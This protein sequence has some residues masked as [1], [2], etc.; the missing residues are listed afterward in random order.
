MR[1][2]VSG[3]KEPITPFLANVRR[4][5]EDLGASVVM[6]IGSA[7]DYFAVAD[8]VLMMDRY[9]LCSQHSEV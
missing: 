7:G 9:G 5:Y 8:H 4:I 3:D 1:Q 6:V 2:L